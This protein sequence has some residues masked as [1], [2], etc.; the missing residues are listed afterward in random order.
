MTP[1]DLTGNEASDL[2]DLDP[3]QSTCVFACGRKGTGKSHFT[4]T[5][6]RAFPYDRLLVDPTGDVDP[7]HAFTEPTEAPVPPRWPTPENWGRPSGER[8]SLRHRPNYRDNLRS[9]RTNLPKWLEEVDDWIGLAMDHGRTAVMLD[10]AGEVIRANRIGPATGD[11][12]H[13]LRH[14]R[15]SLFM[16]CPRPV[17]I[18]P[19]ALSQADLVAI[20][21]TPHELDVRRLG[22]ALGL[23]DKKLYGLI[24]SLDQHEFLLVKDHEIFHCE[25]L[26][27]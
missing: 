3:D 7:Y 16:S 23:N 27:S 18:D 11:M 8:V 25:P 4:T 21:D 15:L 5:L 22:A 2:L 12:L 20:F 24:R 9:K 13:T 26:P 10:D 19:L 6:F 14:R 1:D 17:S